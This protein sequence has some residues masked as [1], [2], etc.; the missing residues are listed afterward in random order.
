M[1]RKGSSAGQRIK[2]IDNFRK[3]VG[4]ATLGLKLSSALIQPTALLDGAAMIGGRAFQGAYDIASSREWRQFLKENFSELRAR[5]ADDPSYLE[6]GGNSFQ[7]KAGRVG[8]WA[9]R[10]IDLLTA[11]SVTAGAYRMAVEDK[12]G[13]V[14]FSKPDADAIVEAQRILRRTQGSAFAKD[15]PSAI[16]QGGLTGNVSLDKLLLQF[17]SFMLNRWSMIQHDMWA[18]GIKEGEIGKAMNIFFFLAMANF[19]EIGIRRFSKELLANM[20]SEDIDDWDETFKKEIVM[21]VL[22]NIPF[23]SQATAAISDGSIPVPAI[24]MS[25]RIIEKLN[26]AAKAKKQSTRDRNLMRGLTLGLGVAFRVPGTVQGEQIM[27]AITGNDK[28]RKRTKS[29]F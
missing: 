14:D 13:K 27:R 28:D 18:G 6:F 7:D 2:I 16:S 15:L 17:Q 19:A 23:I 20:T 22:G 1:A 21:N 24:D 8:F 9:L 29:A 4:V 11:S 5:G 12:G 26:A 3:N 25:A 10:N